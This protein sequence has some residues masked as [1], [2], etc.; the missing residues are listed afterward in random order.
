[1]DLLSF[2]IYATTGLDDCMT[3]DMTVSSENMQTKD[4][5][6]LRELVRD[7]PELRS[8][9]GRRLLDNGPTRLDLRYVIEFVDS[10]RDEAWALLKARVPTQFELTY[11]A[12][13]VAALRDEA[14]EMLVQTKGIELELQS[15]ANVC[16]ELRER[17]WEI[18]LKQEMTTWEFGWTPLPSAPQ[19]ID[20]IWLKMQS[21]GTPNEV[22]EVA[23][24]HPALLNRAIEIGT[25]EENWDPSTFIRIFHLSHSNWDDLRPAK[26]NEILTKTSDIAN[27]LRKHR[28]NM[29]FELLKI[30]ADCSDKFKVLLYSDHERPLIW[31]AVKHDL[32]TW[33]L[34][35][36]MIQIPPLRNEAWEQFKLRYDASDLCSHVPFGTELGDFN[37]TVWLF[38]IETSP[39]RLFGPYIWP[40][41]CLP[42]VCRD[43]DRIKDALSFDSLNAIWRDLDCEDQGFNSIVVKNLASKSYSFTVFISVFGNMLGYPQ[44]YS[45]ARLK[46]PCQVLEELECKH[47][48]LSFKELTRLHAVSPHDRPQIE[49]RFSVLDCNRDDLL[50]LLHLELGETERRRVVM[51]VLESTYS[52]PAWAFFNVIQQDGPR[53]RTIAIEALESRLTSES[54]E[55]LIQIASNCESLA[56]DAF[57][58]ACE[59]GCDE[60]SLLAF[61]NNVPSVRKKAIETLL[62]SNNLSTCA[63]VWL[64]KYFPELMG[65]AV[66]KLDFNSPNRWWAGVGE[67]VYLDVDASRGPDL[68]D[69]EFVVGGTSLQTLSCVG[70][71]IVLGFSTHKYFDEN[72]WYFGDASQYHPDAKPTE[73]LDFCPPSEPGENDFAKRLEREI[74]RSYLNPDIRAVQV[75]QFVQE[76]H[77]E[78]QVEFRSGVVHR[79][80]LT[81]RNSD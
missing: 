44:N 63:L 76:A 15:I 77:V 73:P 45:S 34:E 60:K 53:G 38:L 19:L 13:N 27:E 18:M 49:D 80:W 61:V 75:V 3:N 17:C 6:E 69:W 52:V 46:S 28:L 39:A 66:D 21:L 43:W 56:T 25:R 70:K 37:E 4:A 72:W 35:Q 51:R 68:V 62:K 20:K 9:S 67:L 2:D 40:K 36:V 81:W 65:N 16:P 57:N 55:S 10:L 78:I 7:T 48:P 47:G 11:I 22:C 14:W 12:V 64:L 58:T 30:T 42:F 41:E 29:S 32:D 1:M 26:R 59:K 24:R 8:E 71:R 79:G 50:Q 31:E 54:T 23:V 33:H 5:W 74:N